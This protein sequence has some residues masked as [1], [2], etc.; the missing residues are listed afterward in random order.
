MEGIRSFLNSS[1]KLVLSGVRI[2]FPCLVK[3][4][5]K[6][7]ANSRTPIVYS[8]ELITNIAALTL[9]MCLPFPSAS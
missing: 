8:I 5:L 7:P 1:V 9:S 4:A 3:S 2:Y 6:L